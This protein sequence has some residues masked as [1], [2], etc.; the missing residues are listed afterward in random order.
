M[1]L[2]EQ[3]YP[4]NIRTI[5]GLNN[6]PFQDDVTLVCNTSLAPV[7]INLLSIPANYWNTTWKLYIVDIG[8]AGA[9]NITI[10]V[11]V[12]Y[13]ING[14]SSFVINSNNA[15]LL[16]RIT[17][18]TTFVGQYSVISG[19]TGNGHIIQDEGVNLP[20][21]PILDFVGANVSVTNGAGKTIVTIASGSAPTVWNDIQNLP[22]YDVAAATAAG[23]MPQYTIEGNRIS[24]RGVLFVPL[25]GA[26]TPNF[27]TAQ[28]SYLTI[29]SAITDTS[30]ANL[31]VVTNANGAG[32]ANPRQGKFFTANTS[33][34]RNFPINATPL[35]RDVVFDNVIATRRYLGGKLSL[36]RS[37]VQIR[38]CS[39]VTLL[40]SSVG[41]GAGALAI[42]SPYNF[43][44]AGF[45]NATPAGN[46]SL[47][48]L[49]SRQTAGLTGNDY[50]LAN[51]DTP[52]A[53]P[54]SGYANPFSINAHDIVSLG[55]FFVNL[56][57][58]T[59]F[60]N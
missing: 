5:S 18:N 9:N 51:D 1:G 41:A 50:I 35:S 23:F 46:D 31:S 16:I 57:G 6:V 44:Y 21:Q 49:I 45:V 4:N 40:T 26:A 3:K 7:S 37:I 32:S 38:I 25:D 8:N 17:S 15:S 55:G 39:S 13:L 42:F 36:Y 14:A 43:E 11:P 48:L 58:L 20:Q 30:V 10:N 22:Y 52:F 53:I 29:A 33:T 24:L 54:S 34:N 47:A 19:G 2:F 27:I 56:E 60:I 59:G 12:G 28:N